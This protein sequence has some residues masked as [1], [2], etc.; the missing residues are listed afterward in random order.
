MQ[1]TTKQA[2]QIAK[3]WVFETFVGEDIR[4]VGL[5]EVRISDRNWNITIGFSR[6][7]QK[8]FNPIAVNLNN[9]R[10]YKILTIDDTSGDV[11]EMRNRE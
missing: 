8:V 6:P 3:T 2:V 4:D 7:W 10:S 1:M 11:I 5:E 9:E